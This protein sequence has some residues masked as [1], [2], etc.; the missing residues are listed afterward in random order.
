MEP[1][2]A[3]PMPA[4][5]GS[6]VPWGGGTMQ[7]PATGEGA[8]RHDPLWE[9]GHPATSHHGATGEGDPCHVLP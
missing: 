5:T 9:R 2:G 1:S 7:H 3:E 4:C 6:P 8:P